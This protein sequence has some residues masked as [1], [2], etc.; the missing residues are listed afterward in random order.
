MSDHWVYFLQGKIFSYKIF[1]FVSSL[2]QF[3][4]VLRSYPRN[5][6]MGQPAIPDPVLM[7]YPSRASRSPYPGPQVRFEPPSLDFSDVPLGQEVKR[8]VKIY[9]LDDKTPLEIKVNNKKL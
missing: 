4:L 5:E 6:F 9:N 1:S 7:P 3:Y 8:T 2:Y